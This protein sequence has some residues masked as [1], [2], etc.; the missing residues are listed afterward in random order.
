M[1]K[2]VAK[3]LV[4]S[5]SEYILLSR[6]RGVFRT[7]WSSKESAVPAGPKDVMDFEDLPW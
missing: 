6:P 3:F 4:F 7:S 5:V 1:V 2:I